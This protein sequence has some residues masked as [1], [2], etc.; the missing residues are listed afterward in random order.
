MGGSARGLRPGAPRFNPSCA[1]GHQRGGSSRS[2]VALDAHVVDLDAR[3]CAGA[4]SGA[5]HGAP[6]ARRPAPASRSSGPR[7][8]RAV[9]DRCARRARRP[10]HPSSRTEASHTVGALGGGKRVHRLRFGVV[11]RGFDCSAGAAWRGRHRLPRQGPGPGAG[12]CDANGAA[13]AETISRHGRLRHRRVRRPVDSGSSVSHGCALASQRALEGVA[14]AA[15]IAT[16]RR[17]AA[18]C[19]VGDRLAVRGRRWPTRY[20][21]S[22]LTSHRGGG[23]GR[24]VRARPA[25]RAP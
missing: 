9:R 4:R 25:A 2:L 22:W 16:R 18:L 7:R 20:S 21:R 12:A 5:G 19:G 23:P 3:A 17:C 14:R 6:P 1:R 8:R 15:L 13:R 11:Q 24:R 10:C